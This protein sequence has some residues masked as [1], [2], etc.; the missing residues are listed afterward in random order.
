MFTDLRSGETIIGCLR[1]EG[2]G[3]DSNVARL[4]VSSLLNNASLQSAQSSPAAIVFIRKFRDPLPR[5]LRLDQS[6]GRLHTAWDQ[7][8]KE[9]LQ[10]LTRGAVRPAL[11]AVPPGAEAVVFLDRSEMLACLASDWCE[12][13]V[14]AR[15]WW[16]SLLKHRDTSQIVKELWQRTPEYVPAA[17]EL[18]ANK[19]K[20]TD[21]VRALNA[22][23]T[24]LLLRSVARSFA[25]QT[26]IPVLDTFE[27]VAETPRASSV[28]SEPKIIDRLSN[29]RPRT[30]PLGPWRY[31]VPE[32]GAPGLI[33]EQKF[34]LGITLMLRRAPVKARATDFHQEILEWQ[35][36]IGL[37]RKQDPIVKGG[38][39]DLTGPSGEEASI[40]TA[41]QLPGPINDRV[42]RSPHAVSQAGAETSLPAAVP[43]EP[44]V[45]DSP[46][47]AHFVSENIDAVRVNQFQ[48]LEP[49]APHPENK[50]HPANPNAS[51]PAE[52]LASSSTSQTKTKS[53]LTKA[54]DSVE[55]R[56]SNTQRLPQ[57]F[58]SQSVQ[59]ESPFSEPDAARPAPDEKSF[60]RPDDAPPELFESVSADIEQPEEEWIET[61]L[62]GVFYLINLGIFLGLYCD[63][64]T[65][66]E[67]GIQLSLWDFV[68]LVGRELAGNEIENDPIWPLLARLAQREEGELLGSGFE[69][70]EDFGVSSYDL[71]D[72]PVL[73]EECEIRN[74]KRDTSPGI[75]AWVDRIMPYARARLRK[76]LGLTAEEDPGPIV[77]RHYAQVCLTPAHFNVFFSLAELPIAIRFAGLDR[78]PG[79]VPAA[80]RFIAFHFG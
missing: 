21:F 47:P 35:E 68:A 63:F 61:Q 25:L 58:A 33:P 26:L 77:C 64:T 44:A 24:R 10:R 4:R 59:G 62:G 38:V 40:D 30:T 13:Q 46:I 32:S 27:T 66:E 1:I 17:L 2:A 49:P 36:A 48:P 39:A 43:Q 73:K 52:K 7:A 57:S 18:L 11:G 67:P 42:A 23:E 54:S 56:D 78:D 74:L 80:G 72:D 8:V 28:F 65:P 20:A 15:W 16:Q 60:S 55:P 31:W 34:L 45:S 51:Q 22:A 50:L 3:V 37:T 5:V 12:G 19:N 41:A 76:A 79:W 29:D 70:E 71:G 53:N 9:A 75:A 69:P 6:E 14:T